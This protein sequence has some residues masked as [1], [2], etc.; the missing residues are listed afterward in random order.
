[1]S[2]FLVV[3]S[4]FVILVAWSHVFQAWMNT[5]GVRFTFTGL[6]QKFDK[7]SELWVSEY[8]CLIL[9]LCFSFV[10][11]VFGLPITC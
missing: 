11:I 3:I 1:V 6:F 2:G 10:A 8:I 5:T 9:W 7:M 4:A